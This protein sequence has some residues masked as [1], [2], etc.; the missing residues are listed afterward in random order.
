MNVR[1]PKSLKTARDKKAAA[2]SIRIAVA[3][4]GNG[5]AA[6]HAREKL[7]TGGE[8]R[9]GGRPT[10]FHAQRTANSTPLRKQ[11]CSNTAM[12]RVGLCCTFLE[13]PI[14][15]RAATA[16]YVL[17]LP[18]KERETYID[19]IAQDNAASLVQA[20]EWCARNGVGAFRINSGFLP[21]YTHPDTGY[22]IDDLPRAM[23]FKQ[24]LRHCRKIAE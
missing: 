21:L 16:R 3:G 11:V 14:K 23:A 2:Q 19:Q 17:S 22:T 1:T 10:T 7:A 20:L 5:A 12:V 8:H 4:H 13:E 9:S 24:V 6:R 18:N 15:F